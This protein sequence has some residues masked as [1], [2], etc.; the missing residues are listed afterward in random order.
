[1]VR[2]GYFIAICSLFFVIA[3]CEHDNGVIY[4]NDIQEFQG[5]WSCAVYEDDKEY[6][7]ELIVNNDYMEYTLFNSETYMVY[8]KLAG[9]MVL[10]NE[11]KQAW[12]CN[13]A[14]TNV[15]VQR[16]W[17]VVELDSNKMILCSDMFGEHE[18]NRAYARSIDEIIIEDTLK[19][20]MQY[21]Q[22][23]PLSK[24]GLKEKFGVDNT[25][26]SVGDIV[27]MTNHPIFNKIIFKENYDNDTVYSYTL[28]VDDI[29][30]NRNVVASSMNMIRGVNSIEEYCDSES[31]VNSNNVVI[32]DTASYK[33]TVSSLKGYDYWPNV[34]HYIGM[35]MEDV[36]NEFGRKYV[37]EFREYPESGRSQYDYQTTQD[38]V[39]DW[40]SFV[41]DSTGTVKHSAV[42]L[43]EK[44]SVKQKELVI[45]LLDNKYHFAKQ[46]D[47]IY[48][49][50]PCV[51]F[52]R[53]KYEIQYNVENRAI[54]YFGLE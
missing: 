25:V 1:M 18:F 5:I 44:Y 17:D 37:Y 49:Y 32:V 51:D 22:F 42:F 19:E 26:S 3:A 20:L 31:L 2:S 6:Q 48:Y 9:S 10:G 34:S 38:G 11:N 8:D 21:Q 53:A 36:K 43:L 41:T 50:Y 14:I 45:H 4:H 16:F 52:E 47:G 54:M 29:F 12:Y 23:L 13:S 35:P 7:G 15:N 30:K 33:M 39:C 28:L 40:I 46:E 24:T 27:Y